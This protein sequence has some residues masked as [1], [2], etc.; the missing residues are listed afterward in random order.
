MDYT[1]DK[2]VQR[3]LECLN[4]KYKILD[5]IFILTKKQE[6]NISVDGIESLEKH[7]QEK[8][9]KIDEI[10]KIDEEF[11]VYFSR[12]KKQY[13]IEKITDVKDLDIDG[14]K[15]LQTVTEKIVFKIR[16]L[17]ELEQQNMRNA[18]EVLNK[19]GS[20]MKKLGHIKKAN[21]AYVDI[22][23]VHEGS[24]FIDKKK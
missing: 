2:Y 23:R 13:N 14:V 21:T 15:E 12:F 7:V 17:S 11:N 16:E 5:E 22:S 4:K 10:N 3:L 20:E 9:T 6:E 1:P 24:H 19:I 8:Q 18:K